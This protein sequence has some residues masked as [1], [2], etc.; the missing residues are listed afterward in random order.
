MAVLFGSRYFIAYFVLRGAAELKYGPVR[1]N[2]RK[3][4]QYLRPCYIGLISSLYCISVCLNAQKN[5]ER[6]NYLVIYAW[7]N[8]CYRRNKIGW[9]KEISLAHV[10]TLCAN[11]LFTQPV[12]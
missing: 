4:A 10:Y 9:H 12:R 8:C 5:M 3:R 11:L 6:L 2:L 7:P 1:L